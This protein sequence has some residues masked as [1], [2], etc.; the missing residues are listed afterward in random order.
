[1]LDVYRAPQTGKHI[2][3]CYTAVVVGLWFIATTPLNCASGG[4]SCN[5]DSK[6]SKL[7]CTNTKQRE[8][9]ARSFWH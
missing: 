5:T 3:N 9:V 8:S 4:H 7:N 1:M 6:D 2:Y